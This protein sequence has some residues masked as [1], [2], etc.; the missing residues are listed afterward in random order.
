MC[1]L[2]SGKPQNLHGLLSGCMRV[3]QVGIC[4]CAPADIYIFLAGWMIML[5][6][7]NNLYLKSLTCT[8]ISNQ[9]K[10]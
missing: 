5:I 6:N 8:C 1:R 2:V 4:S 10:L 9:C 3:W 7:N